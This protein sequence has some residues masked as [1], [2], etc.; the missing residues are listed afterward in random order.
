M[1]ISD[2]QALTEVQRD[3]LREVAN[4]G[5]G[6]AATALSLMTGT[7]I[8]ISVPTIT[9]SPL[10][11]LAPLIASGEEQVALV[12]MEMSGG[13]HGHTILAFPL[14]TAHRLAGLMLRRE[15]RDEARR[16]QPTNRVR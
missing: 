7:R 3:A 2:V 11:E 16:S 4:I 15:P 5:A 9:L 6:H 13:M 14:G 1:S 10:E 8:M 12:P